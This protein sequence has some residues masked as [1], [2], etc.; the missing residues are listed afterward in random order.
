MR[1]HGRGFFEGMGVGLLLGAIG[2]GIVGFAGGDDECDQWCF[3]SK[4]E[5][6]AGLFALFFGILG[7]PTGG[8]IGAATGSKE[9]YLI[10]PSLPQPPQD[11]ILSIPDPV[12]DAPRRE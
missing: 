7:V 10:G 5:E 2:G 3:Y 6:K 1:N 4:A 12:S 11:Q 8:I 9:R